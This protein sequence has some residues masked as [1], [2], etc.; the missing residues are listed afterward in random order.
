MTLK[1]T[2][3]A[4]A[5]MTFLSAPA[6]A[7]ISEIRAGLTEF[8]ETT[9]GIN[10]GAGMGRENSIG[11]NAE[12]IFDPLL[13]KDK[14]LRL[15]PYIGGMVNLNGDTSY[16]AA[17]VML[18]KDFTQKFYGDIGIGLAVHDGRI[19]LSDLPRSERRDAFLNGISFGSRFLFRPQITLGYRIDDNWAGEVFMDHLSNGNV[20]DSTGINEGVDNLGIRVARRF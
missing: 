2:L 3:T 16:A 11:I 17:G 20:L 1:T 12:L 5:L 13:G 18:R 7:Q 19:Q 9:T 6:H 14:S 4:F 10:W 15:H 8:D